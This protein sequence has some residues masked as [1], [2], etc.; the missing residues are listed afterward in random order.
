MQH[1]TPAEARADYKKQVD[2]I[3]EL[4]GGEW[5]N[6]D[7]PIAEGCAAASESG[8]YYRGARFRRE[9]IADYDAAGAAAV[10]YW[11]VRG[12]E[13]RSVA[14]RPTHRLVTGIAPNGTTIYLTLEDNRNR[15][16][17]EGPCNEGN[18]DDV[19][20]DDLRRVKEQRRNTSPPNRRRANRCAQI[21]SVIDARNLHE[22][23][24]GCT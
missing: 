10:A 20:M 6:Y 8:F 11:E 18:W 3:Q 21:P 2:A 5:D 13:V 4:L 1:M 14:Y 7:S 19:S 9:P 16:G 23:R 22:G 17:A 12:Y 24:P 15:I